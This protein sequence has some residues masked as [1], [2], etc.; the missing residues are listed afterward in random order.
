MTSTNDI[1]QKLTSWRAPRPWLHEAMVGDAVNLLHMNAVAE[2]GCKSKLRPP[3]RELATWTSKL[4][5]E[6]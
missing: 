1:Q 2:R 4:W 3:P 6:A 5:D